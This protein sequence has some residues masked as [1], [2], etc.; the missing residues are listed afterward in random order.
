MKNDFTRFAKKKIAKLLV[1][2]D[3]KNNK[4]S[5]NTT[6]GMTSAV[7][8]RVFA[9]L[10]MPLYSETANGQANV[11]KKWCFTSSEVCLLKAF[12]Q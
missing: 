6:E 11:K 3:T 1:K 2:E 9:R 12:F 10:N 4:E 5:G 7:Q 8:W